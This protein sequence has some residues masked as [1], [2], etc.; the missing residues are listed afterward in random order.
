MLIGMNNN[1]KKNDFN[2]TK[3]VVT[4]HMYDE[5]YVRYF[6]PF[7]HLVTPDKV[8]LLFYDTFL[9]KEAHTSTEQ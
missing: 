3:V 7:Y 4:D 6:I 5:K 9:T 8:L 2:I 1:R